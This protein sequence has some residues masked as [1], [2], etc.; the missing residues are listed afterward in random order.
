M[1]AT[2]GLLSASALPTSASSG[3][4]ADDPVAYTMCEKPSEVHSAACALLVSMWCGVTGRAMMRAPA[5]MSLGER[6]R[7]ENRI[8]PVRAQLVGIELEA[9]RVG[10]EE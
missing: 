9:G 8:A 6:E 4:A 5:C 7:V 10:G 2:G 3:F 1:S